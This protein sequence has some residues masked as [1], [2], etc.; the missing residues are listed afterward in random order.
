M[1]QRRYR[2]EGLAGLRDRSPRPHH[3]RQPTREQTVGQIETL[4]RR[5][6]TGKAIAA[7]VGISP[8]TVS[9]ILKRPGPKS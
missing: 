2:A 3:L 7:E 9:C 1:R 5:R 6:W 8:A 4:R